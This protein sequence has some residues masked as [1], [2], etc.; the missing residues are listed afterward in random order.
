MISANPSKDGDAKP[1]VYWN[2]ACDTQ[3][4]YDSGV[5]TVATVSMLARPL[6]SA[7]TRDV[8][9]NNDKKLPIAHASVRANLSLR[10]ER[11][12]CVA[13]TAFFPEH[14]SAIQR[15]SSDRRCRARSQGMSN[16]SNYFREDLPAAGPAGIDCRVIGW[17]L[18]W[19]LER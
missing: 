17:M 16:D 1:P 7:C 5:A 4:T 10:F 3:R 13:T 14:S 19:R 9:K 2:T 15:R 8:V 12:G 18:R 6:A 11:R